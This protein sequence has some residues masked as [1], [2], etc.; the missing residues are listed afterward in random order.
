MAVR[1]WVGRF[2]VVD[3]HV[4]EEGAWLKSLVRQRP[5]DEPDEIYVLVEPVGP[6]DPQFASQLVEVIT[7][8]YQKDPLSLT[9][10]QMRS[11]RSAHEH[12][13]E[14]NRKSLKEHRIGAGASCLTLRGSE[15]YLAQAGPSLAYLRTH[16]GDVR[17][18]EPP[19]RDEEHSLGI[20]DPFEPWVTR[21]A[22]QPGDLL[23]LASSRLDAIAPQDHIERMLER[24][25]DDALPELY[26]LCRDEPNMSVVLLSCFEE[27]DPPE[28]LTRSPDDSRGAAQSALAAAIPPADAGPPEPALATVSGDAPGT[29]SASLSLA[30]EAFD[31]PRRPI[32]EE[33]R[34]IAATNAPPPSPG[35]RVRE[36]AMLPRY[37]RST[38]SGLPEVRIPRLAI[39]AVL[40]VALVGLVAWWQL[41]GSV[42]ENREERFAT[43]LDGAREDNARAQ[44]TADRALKRQLLLSAQSKLVDAADIRAEDPALLA[45]REDVTSALRLLDAVYEVRGFDPVVDLSQTV[46]GSVE[47]TQAVI[48]GGSAFFLDAEERRVLRAALDGSAPPEE[49]LREGELG[50]AVTAG[51]PLAIAWADQI[52]ALVMIDDQRQA[53]AYFPDGGTIPMLVRDA[54]EWGSVTALAAAAGNLYVLDASSSQVWRYLPGQ[55]GYDSERT[56]LL[57]AP[58]FSQATEIAVGEDI[59]ILD[60]EAGIRRFSGAT[61]VPFPLAGIDRPLLEPASLAVLPGSNRLIV[62]DRGNQRVVLASPDGEFLRQIVSTAFTDLRAVWVDEG[63]STIYVLNGDALLRG[64]FPP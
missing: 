57:D 33:V 23:L 22:L 38:G 62:A 15:V 25:A 13:R 30:G 45:L 36:G 3:G 47:I 31:L 1:T 58:D 64:A 18:I 43:L 7:R 19:Q 5:D 11:L 9:G 21:I 60:R 52:S 35:L 41:P 20:A 6:G 2:C 12:L 16:K 14:W 49:I 63:T 32:K 48:G 4:E 46:T 39:F 27:V 55:G 29:V 24:G 17:R 44:A 26:L 37:K 51:R 53:F 40:A 10:A 50:G 42:Q 28:Y 54:Q 8:L 56:G 34:D 61:E 59:Y